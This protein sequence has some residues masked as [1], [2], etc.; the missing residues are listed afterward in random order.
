[1]SAKLYLYGQ[2]RWELSTGFLVPP[3]REK[4]QA[5]IAFIALSGNGA[6]GRRQ[7]ANLLWEHGRDPGA[8]LRQSVREIKALET[9]H[10]SDLFSSDKNYLKLDLS[11]LWV[12]V[13]LAKT[14]THSFKTGLVDQL[15]E[16]KLGPL[17]QNCGVVEDAFDDWLMTERSR[18]ENDLIFVLE[19]YLDRVRLQ[20]LQ[21][22]LLK[23]VAASLLDA[24]STNEIA[25]RSLMKVAME[26]GDRATAVRQY[27]LCCKTIERELGVEPSEE[28]Q[29]L[30]LKIKSKPTN[31]VHLRAV[32]ISHSSIIRNTEPLLKPVIQ[33]TPFTLSLNEDI[34][35]FFAQTIHA[36]ICEQLTRNRRFSV[37]DAAAPLISG[38]S[39]GREN[40][41]LDQAPKYIVRGNS[42][43][44][45]DNLTFLI[46]LYEGQTGD[47][48]W[49]TRMTIDPLVGL[50]E[51]RETASLAA[52]EMIRFIELKESEKVNNI[53]DGLL[54]ARQ[55]VIRAVSIMF[56]FSADA[57]ARAERYL[58]RALLLH[59]D[60]PEALAWLAFLRSI[61]IG[62][63]YTADITSA[64]DEIG[65][66]V[67][68]SIELSPHDD[69]SLAIAGHLEAFIHHDFESALEYFQRALKANPNCAYAW[70]FNAI[71]NCYIGKPAEALSMLHQCRQIMPF[72]PHPYY[73]DTARCIASMLSGKY[74]DAVRIG[75][76]VLRNNPNFHANYRP[77]ISSLGHLGRAEEA[78]PVMDEFVKYQPDF[79][80]S[81]HLENYP[82][83]DDDKT[84]TYI[85]GLRKAGVTE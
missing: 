51:S 54:N 78:E 13:R 42:L 59:P 32:E 50:E 5:L 74:E 44:G 83:L 43:S 79:S 35:S 45:L 73:F 38:F 29:A 66:L 56:K 16:C 64:R 65:M 67:R 57:V 20:G 9:L 69:V 55:C 33:V 53:E 31:G 6:V 68:H 7:A 27:D 36:D 2:F 23:R 85:E 84:E 77:L 60:Y 71:T 30:A 81:W 26:E 21:S 52:V 70:G 12:D 3:L 37:R 10:D 80:V 75:R 17:L 76:Q 63:G 41:E 25:H 28:T 11:K 47:I 62:Q 18:R 49:M 61:E 14:C 82:P 22:D 8:S 19:Q 4:T 1:M 34:L 40:I 24:D 39:N 15:L 46:Q 48:L 72:D 58:Q